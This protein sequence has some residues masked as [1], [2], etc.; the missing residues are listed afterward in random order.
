LDTE[1]LSSLEF[2]MESVSLPFRYRL[3][4]VVAAFA[5]LLLPLAYA[6]LTLLVGLGVWYHATHNFTWLF[7][8]GPS[9]LKLLLYAGPILAG[10]LCVLFML[11]PLFAPREMRAKPRTIERDEQPLLYGYVERLC[12]SLGAPPPVRIDLDMN[13]N[14]AARFDSGLR[15]LLRGDPVLTLG[16][17][18]VAGMTVDQL[19]GVLAHELGHFRQ[20]SAMRFYGVI[21]AVNHWFARVVYERDRW[22]E[23]LDSLSSDPD[24]G[25]FR[26][27][28]G[29]S[30]ALIWTSRRILTGLMLA[31]HFVSAFLSRQME[32]NADLHHAY[33]AGSEAFRPAHLRMRLL[34]VAWNQTLT[35]LSDLWTERR[36]TEDF[37]SLVVS[38]VQL[39]EEMPDAVEE[40]ESEALSDDTGWLD[41]HP[42]TADRIQVVEALGLPPRVTHTV[43]GSILFQHFAQ[44]C[45]QMTVNFYTSVLSLQIE[46]DCLFPADTV[47]D[48]RRTMIERS[49]APHL[50]HFGSSL[51]LVGVFPEANTVVVEDRGN[52]AARLET[53]REGLRVAAPEVETVMKELDELSVRR[54]KASFY[55]R[56]SK[57]WNKLD[58]G[59]FQIA[60]DEAGDTEAVQ[61]R[62][63]AERNAL[64]ERLEP[65]RAMSAERACLALSV[66]ANPTLAVDVGGETDVVQRLSDLFTTLQS[67]EINWQTMRR[68]QAAVLDLNF[69]YGMEEPT[70]TPGPLRR[71]YT[72]LWS[73]LRSEMRTLKSVT[74][75]ID[76]P[77][78]HGCE[79]FTLG[80]Y[81]LEEIPVGG[82]ALEQAALGVMGRFFTV[83][84][85]IWTDMASLALR[86]EA[87][88]GL[89]PISEDSLVRQ[90]DTKPD[91]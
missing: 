1:L 15:G 19:T 75:E 49:R 10:S 22:D 24:A 63:E 29:A 86:V 90:R 69:L 72:E 42:S 21:G 81:L 70:T 64:L 61:E 25:W 3:G 84:Q 80:E 58:P 45:R 34:F 66:A 56:G 38:E 83:F 77:Y 31:G 59:T 27:L 85:R 20:R 46:P 12:R 51:L 47:A 23:D 73:T 4:L 44:L 32:F 36:L 74:G 55:A 78:E 41:T 8:A 39:L 43:S 6:G 37:V 68:I 16:L 7:S 89:P 28:A 2:E 53:L 18:L 40:I 57:I 88:L 9:F 33:V 14:A 65:A 71:S 82:A 11:K 91:S 52:A 17:P 30:K 26:V 48:E 60:A 62:L 35:Y 5:M 67:L 79:R 13:V 50:F 76:Y 54:R 87:G